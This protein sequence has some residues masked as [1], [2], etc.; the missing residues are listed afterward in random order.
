MVRF[1]LCCV[2]GYLFLCVFHE[3]F[4]LRFHCLV[5]CVFRCLLCL[6]AMFC[7]W[8][9]LFLSNVVCV[10][11]CLSCCGCACVALCVLCR[12]VVVLVVLLIVVCVGDHALRLAVSLS[13]FVSCVRLC[14]LLGGVVCGCA[15]CVFCFER[16]YRICV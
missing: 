1:V 8:R 6:C 14:F 9:R 7:V 12:C 5:S 13:C 11:L 2:C 10:S 4:W 16:L 15:L 3:S